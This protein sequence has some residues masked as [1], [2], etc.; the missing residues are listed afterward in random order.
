MDKINKLIRD[1]KKDKDLAEVYRVET[2]V[3]GTDYCELAFIK[4]EL[5]ET[6]FIG[7]FRIE[8]E[9]ERPYIA[10]LHPLFDAINNYTYKWLEPILESNY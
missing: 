9:T 5:N 3:R 1:F 7:V 2:I 8:H 6:G 4:K 10:R